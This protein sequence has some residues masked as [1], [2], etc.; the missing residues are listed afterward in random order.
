MTNVRVAG[1]DVGTS[2]I[3]LEV[4]DG[5]VVL[6]KIVVNNDFIIEGNRVEQN[7]L[8]LLA[9]VKQ[10]IEKAKG[11]GAKCFGFATYRGSILVWENK[12]KPVSNIITWMDRRSLEEYNKLPLKAR[13]LSKLP[14]IGATLSP[15]SPMV[16]LKILS[17]EKPDI[18]KGLSSG[19]MHAWNIDGY[20]IESLTNKFMSDP[21]NMGLMGVINPKD[22]KPIW[23]TTKLLD[24]P[25]IPIPEPLYHNQTIVTGDINIGPFMGDQQAANHGLDCLTAGCVRVS[26]GSGLFAS[27]IVGGNIKLPTSKG[28]VPLILYKEENRGLYGLESYITGLGKAVEWFVENLL[29][30]NYSLLDE[31]STLEGEPPLILP[32]FWGLRYPRIRK[33]IAGVVGIEP[34]YTIKDIAKGVAHA[35]AASIAYLLENLG[36]AGLKPSRIVLTGGLTRLD[37]LTRLVA[38]YLGRE[39]ERSVEPDAPGRGVARLAAKACGLDEPSP[40]PTETVEPLENVDLIEPREIFELAEEM[41]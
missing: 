2:K 3:K 35:V 31:A 38:S 14:I 6:K 7:P 29:Q 36:S 30:G 12:S 24:L 10:L 18:L 4:Y 28:I 15:E 23:I 8:E 32:F 9:K 37:N 11:Y 17:L 41:S 34:G 39:V 19:T 26:M 33:G 13:I 5:D 20:L 25:K 27:I 22:L 40:I 1:I 16:K 21:S